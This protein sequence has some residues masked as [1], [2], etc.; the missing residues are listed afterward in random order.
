MLN[1]IFHY[2]FEELATCR[3]ESARYPILLYAERRKADF[4]QFPLY[5]DAMYE[6]WGGVACLQPNNLSRTPKYM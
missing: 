4:I 1:S 3:M 2:V 6:L 5:P